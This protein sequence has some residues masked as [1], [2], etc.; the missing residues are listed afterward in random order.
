MKFAETLNF[1]VKRSFYLNRSKSQSITRIRET[2]S[3]GKPIAVI[4]M[5]SVTRPASG[6]PAAPTLATVEVI[7]KCTH[8]ISLTIAFILPDQ[9][10]ITKIQ[11]QSFI[12][13]KKY[14]S[15]SFIQCSTI[16]IY[17]GTD[18]Q[19]QTRNSRVNFVIIFKVLN[20]NW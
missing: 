13:C 12:L 16:H 15:N 7:L 5:S 20:C 14:S 2:R 3:A 1:K 17:C 4:T 6:I 9:N 18:R 10:I 8:K 11:I 19:N